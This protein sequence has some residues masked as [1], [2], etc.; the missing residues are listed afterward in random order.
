MDNDFPH[1]RIVTQPKGQRRTRLRHESHC[2]RLSLNQNPSRAVNFDLR[3]VA[4]PNAGLGNE[5]DS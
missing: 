3:A 1:P 2:W 5:L 4:V